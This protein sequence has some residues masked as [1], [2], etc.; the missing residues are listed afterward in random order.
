[1]NTCLR[2]A[3]EKSLIADKD[4]SLSN[5]SFKENYSEFVIVLSISSNISGKSTVSINVFWLN[6]TL[7]MLEPYF[8]RI[9]LMVEMRSSLNLIYL[10]YFRLFSINYTLMMILEQSVSW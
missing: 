5:K 8:L 2:Q 6:G 1:M 10:A 7:F 3:K 9:V 4:E